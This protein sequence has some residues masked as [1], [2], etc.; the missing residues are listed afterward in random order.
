MKLSTVRQMF[1]PRLFANIKPPSFLK[2]T[3]FLTSP[4][5]DAETRCR[6]LHFPHQLNDIKHFNTAT[7]YGVF[8]GGLVVRRR[9]FVWVSLP[10]GDVKSFRGAAIKISRV[11]CTL[12]KTAVNRFP[13][14]I[15]GVLTRII[16]N[17]T[18]L[19]LQRSEM[20]RLHRSDHI[21]P[22]QVSEWLAL[23]H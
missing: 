21:L 6:Y 20:W 10:V 12:F 11:R 16:P 17:R 8:S 7:K 22:Q 14:Y 15:R 9:Q 2:L 19:S 3:H 1:L 4:R 13:L 18:S 5:R 23:Q